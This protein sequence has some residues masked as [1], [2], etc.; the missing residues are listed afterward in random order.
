MGATDVVGSGACQVF[1]EA[2]ARVV[3][4]TRTEDKLKELLGR[5]DMHRTNLIGVVGGLDTRAQIEE[6]RSVVRAALNG[7]TVDHVISSFGTVPLTPDG[8]STG[9]VN[10]LRTC[11]E[12]SLFPTIL[13]AQVFMQDLRDK[14]GSTYTIVSGGFAHKCHF[15]RAWVGAIKS[16][17]MNGVIESLS[18][19]MANAKVR[20]NGNCL[21][22]GLA[23]PSDDKNHYQS[24]S[25]EPE[26]SGID[27]AKTFLKIIERKDLRGQII[28]HDNRGDTDR[29]LQA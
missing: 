19:D 17:A 6:I 13:C 10:V 26:S 4:V 1:L 20:V 8:I 18:C 29:F 11:F 9:D 15:P 16:A 23:K 5:F 24:S 2:G 27:F 7:Y 14:E 3:V 21:H 28:C 25:G 12:D 22:Y